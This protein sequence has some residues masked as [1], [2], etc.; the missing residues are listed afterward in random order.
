[1]EV[2]AMRTVPTPSIHTLQ[3]LGLGITKAFSLHIRNATKQYGSTYDAP[4]I[5]TNV[6]K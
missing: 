4:T 3:Q 1:M 6:E 2:R 5:T